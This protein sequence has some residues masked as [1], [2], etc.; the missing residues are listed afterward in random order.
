MV[1]GRNL[2]VYFAAVVG[3]PSTPVD[4]LITLA[5]DEGDCV[6][7]AAIMNLNFRC[8]IQYCELKIFDNS[9]GGNYG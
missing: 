9:I 1:I 3:N 6:R 5:G 8:G 2:H 7:S 4:T